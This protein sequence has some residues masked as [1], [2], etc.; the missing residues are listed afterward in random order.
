MDLVRANP[1][2]KFE[3]GR[4]FSVLIFLGEVP[5]NSD[6]W[7]SSK[8][9]VGVHHVPANSAVERCQNCRS[10]A[11]SINEGFIH[12]NRHLV[13][14]WPLWGD[15]DPADLSSFLVDKLRWRVTDVGCL[16]YSDP[17]SY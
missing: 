1:S 9:F 14:N 5:R 15:L 11:D 10:N 6:H 16:V 8:S 13:S 12:L 7:M 3:L 4:S 17:I 2:K